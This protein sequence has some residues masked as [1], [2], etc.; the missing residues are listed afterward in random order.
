MATL[1]FRVFRKLFFIRD[2]LITQDAKSR[3]ATIVW[4]PLLLV[5]SSKADLCIF[6]HEHGYYYTASSLVYPDR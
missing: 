1:H 5:E 3:P 6:L 2:L 4:F